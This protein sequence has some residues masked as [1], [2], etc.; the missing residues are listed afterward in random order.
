VAGWAIRKKSARDQNLGCWAKAGPRR[1]L[2]SEDEG[3]SVASGRFVDPVPSHR[4]RDDARPAPATIEPR[5]MPN[6]WSRAFVALCVVWCTLMPG[7]LAA[8][9]ADYNAL[10]TAVKN[11]SRGGR[12]GCQL[13]LD[14][15]ELRGPEL[16]AMRRRGV[17]RH[18]Q[19]G[20]EPRDGHAQVVPGLR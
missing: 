4:P 11:L 14:G 8:P 13:L 16:G 15:P 3:L 6:S 12:I 20:H 1:A 2:R 10:K 5:G 17:R 19:L 9:F 18:A 7:A